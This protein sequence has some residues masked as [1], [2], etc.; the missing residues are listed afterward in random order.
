M[1]SHS[2]GDLNADRRYGYAQD[3][4][5]ERDFAAAADL[6]RQVLELTP[7]RPPAWFGLGKALEQ[8]GD[9]AEAIVAFQRALTLAPDDV[10]G[11]GVRLERYGIAGAC[12]TQGYVAA[13]FDEYADRFDNHLIKALN[14]HGPQIV[15]AALET[16]CGDTGRTFHFNR[17]VDL[18][19]GTGLMA[20]AIWKHVD[21]ILGVDL[22]GAMT[23]KARQS[24]FY[25]E[26]EPS[27]GD[28]MEY[29]AF[30]ADESFDLLMAADVLVYLG[31]LAPVFRAAR[32]VLE[33]GGLF[34]F[35]VQSLA[36]SGYSL[37]ADLRYHHSE[38]YLRAETEIS[39]LEVRLLAPCVT[40]QDAG[41]PVH[42]FVV[43]L[44][45]AGD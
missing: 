15:M 39:A 35:T 9:T 10:L 42:C 11:A 36:S 22:S 4:L 19:C 6:F 30:Q 41:R 3:L 34:A 8:S 23:A 28:L 44:E 2:S 13:L 14:Y 17:A 27:C 18:G 5:K 43:V 26:G 21:A 45:R 29:L 32:R 20:A 40:R 25:A 33:T 24:G 38:A 31:D 37:G 12:M 7:E 16:V 1:T